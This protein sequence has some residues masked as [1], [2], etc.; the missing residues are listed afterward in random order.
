MFLDVS[1][2]YIASMFRTEENI[3]LSMWFDVDGTSGI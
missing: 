2:E 1:E 3:N